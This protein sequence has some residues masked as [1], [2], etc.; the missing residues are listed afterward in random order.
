MLIEDAKKHNVVVMDGTHND[1]LK[2][3]LYMID[4]VTK[5]EFG[6]IKCRPLDS[7]HPS[8]VVCVFKTRSSKFKLIQDLIEIRYPK[9]CTFD[10]PL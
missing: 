8:I 10:A 9:L 3:I 7:K 6:R 1:V 2:H 4:D 5:K